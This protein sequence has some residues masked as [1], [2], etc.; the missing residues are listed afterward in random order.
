MRR[1]LLSCALLALFALPC[2]AGQTVTSTET[3]IQLTVEPMAAPAPALRYLL[4]PELAEM[5]PG[6]PIPVYLRC[7]MDQDFTADRETL[8]RSAL[9]QADWA[10]RLDTPDWQ[11]LLKL[12]ADGINLLLPD[13]QKL[14]TLATGLQQR[15]RTEIAQHR[16]NDGLRTAKTMFAL[17][18][19][20]GEHPTLIGGLVGVAIASVTIA[21]LEEL[22]EQPG[23]PNLYWALTNLPSPLISMS[24]GMEGERLFFQVELRDLSDSIPMNPDQLKKLIAHLD[25]LRAQIDNKPRKPGDATGAWLKARIKDPT[26]V[27]A[28]RRRLMELGIPEERLLRFPPEQVLL[29][30]Q[31]R[32]F[33]VRRDEY[34]KLVKLPAWQIE[35]MA[36]K[37]KPAKEGTLFGS[38][39]P[40]IH[41]VRRAQTRLEQ[42][43]ALLR[44]VEALRLY[45]AEHGGQLPQK[46]ADIS[47]PLPDDPVTGKPFP[48]TLEGGTAH[49][50]GT[51]PGQEQSPFLKI[52]YAVTIRK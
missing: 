5:N 31:K 19:H 34:L 27:P 18:R 32:E 30:D 33:E 41:R 10:A 12:K 43:I 38:F 22:L 44:H 14:R 50:R 52:H 1:T 6:N 16:L 17:A 15:F 48:Y 26:V 39:D 21:P 49:V 47:V 13:V 11:V 36:A 46:L 20:T 51:P 35:A 37:L 2:R 7:W 29:L 4:L 42:R 23:C 40:A 28:A 9:R 45:A 25:T 8:G 3:I 24:K